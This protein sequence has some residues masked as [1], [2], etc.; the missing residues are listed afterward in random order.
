[1]EFKLDMA[2]I[3]K[4]VAARIGSTMRQQGVISSQILLEA[5]SGSAN[6]GKDM[7]TYMLS[8]IHI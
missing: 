1:M 6:A 3:S 4:E 5:S 2:R 8:L 7:I